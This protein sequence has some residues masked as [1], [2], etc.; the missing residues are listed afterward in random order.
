[1]LAND[2]ETARFNMVA[3]QIRPWEVIDERVLDTLQKVPRERFVDPE[4]LGL[5]FADVAVPIGEGQSM[6]KPVQE[7]RMLQALNVQPGNSVLEIGTGSGLVTACLA[8]LGGSVTS[9]EIHPALSE[10]AATRL[11]DNGVKNVELVVGDGLHAA[12]VE[13]QMLSRQAVLHSLED[14]GFS[15]R[16][17]ESVQALHES[18]LGSGNG[19]AESFDLV[20]LSTRHANCPAEDIVD[21]VRRWSEGELCKT[22]LFT[23]TTE[24][25]PMLDTLPRA[26]CQ[27]LSKPVCTRKLFRGALHLLRPSTA[28]PAPARASSVEPRVRV[29]CVDDNLANLKLVEA[30]L[31]DM[32]AEVLTATSGEDALELLGQQQVDLVFMDVQMPGMDGRQT[33][34]ELRQREDAADAPAVPIVALTAHALAGERRQLLKCGMND[35]MSKPINPE[36]LRH[37]VQK[38]TGVTLDPLADSTPE[39]ERAVLAAPAADTEL[40]PAKALPTRRVLDRQEGLRLAAGKADLAADML[41]MLIDG[42]PRE[43]QQIEQARASA[44]R[45]ALLE[46]VHRLHGA[47][48]YC[49]V[50]ELRACCNEAESLIKQNRDSAAAVEEIL[51]AIERLQREYAALPS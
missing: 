11:A 14:L 8:A 3:Q 25:Y 32:G 28:A 40:P 36:Q 12:L 45:G 49:G 9:Y 5:A 2:L 4:Y 23:D 46:A 20:L 50:P 22:L 1:M 48:R 41:A 33:T 21:M 34:A 27:V 24:H 39:A 15:V 47:T 10:K 35:Y 38:W 26:S 13:P 18:L 19:R 29:L 37:C 51:Q 43:R 6:M 42:L 30:L 44:D 17:F 7:A 31:S 16:T